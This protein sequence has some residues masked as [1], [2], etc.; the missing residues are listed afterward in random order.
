M[1]SSKMG[2]RMHPHG[3]V[4]QHKVN[5]A[6]VLST[7]HVKVLDREAPCRMMRAAA[8]VVYHR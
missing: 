1:S 2:K 4:A 5:A 7:Q 6:F 3:L 8:V